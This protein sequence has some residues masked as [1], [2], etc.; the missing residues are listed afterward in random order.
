MGQVPSFSTYSLRIYY[1]PGTGLST[2]LEYGYRILP[3]WSFWPSWRD[4][5]IEAMTYRI[6][7]AVMEGSPRLQGSFGEGGP[8][9][10]V[11]MRKVFL[12]Y[13]L[14]HQVIIYQDAT[15]LQR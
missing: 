6:I 2:E 12:M 13:L 10:E 8:N 1:V 15:G 9:S 11:N 5:N 4:R 7:N 3:V 14:T